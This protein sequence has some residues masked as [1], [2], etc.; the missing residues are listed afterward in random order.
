LPF[1]RNLHKKGLL[2]RFVIDEAHCVS[3]WGSTFRP[4]YIK[5]GGLLEKFR[6]KS[7]KRVPVMALTATSSL[8][9]CKEVIDLLKMDKKMRK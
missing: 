1:L 8:D 2:S 9:D 7:S 5:L 3:Q 4:D 6:R